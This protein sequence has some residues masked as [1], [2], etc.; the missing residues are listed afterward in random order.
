[1]LVSFTS[2]MTP[3]NNF[4]LAGPSVIANSGSIILPNA[5]IC[6]AAF[7]CDSGNSLMAALNFAAASGPNSCNLAA[8]APCAAACLALA[9]AFLASSP[10][11]LLMAFNC[12]M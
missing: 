5:N 9:S 12:T 11:K 4:L 2:S 6:C 1:M 7:C 3:D 10:V 8:T